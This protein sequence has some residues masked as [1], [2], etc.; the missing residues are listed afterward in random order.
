MELRRLW[1]NTRHAQQAEIMHLLW[2]ISFADI[3]NASVEHRFFQFKDNQ[4]CIDTIH[5]Y[6]G[7]QS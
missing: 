6:E 7:T 1:A 4:E 5:N 2:L 3:C